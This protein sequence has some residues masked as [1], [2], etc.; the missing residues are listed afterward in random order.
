MRKVCV[1][2]DQET[3]L[4]GCN[5]TEPKGTGAETNKLG[6][7][8]KA[9]RIFL[10]PEDDVHLVSVKCRVPGATIPMPSVLSAA[11]REIFC[12]A[13]TAKDEADRVEQL[14]HNAAVLF[15][16][17]PQAKV[18]ALDP[19]GGVRHALVEFCES[20][21]IELLLLGPV[22]MS[23]GASGMLRS[24]LGFG[25]V[26]EYSLHHLDI[27]VCVF[28]EY[29]SEIRT[30]NKVLVCVDSLNGHDG[31]ESLLA[32]VLKNVCNE[33]IRHRGR[34]QCLCHWGIST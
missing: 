5:N 16:D 11:D 7:F 2:I 4:N 1:A 15:N 12:P 30:S 22:R 6:C 27:P 18:H 21:K 14:L 13:D 10:R 31:V 34:R 8:R 3:P 26:S 17:F 25:S 23:S 33:D 29:D 9:I 24:L 19:L 20:N 28:H 32:W